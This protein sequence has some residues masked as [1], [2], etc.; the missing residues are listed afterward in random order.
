MTKTVL[1]NR[2]GV[3]LHTDSISFEE[4]SLRTK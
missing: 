4:T 1:D 3:V 2:D